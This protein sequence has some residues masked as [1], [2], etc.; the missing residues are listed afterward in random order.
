MSVDTGESV[1]DL[2]PP[3]PTRDIKGPIFRSKHDPTAPPTCSTFGRSTAATCLVTN[4]GGDTKS[5]PKAHPWKTEHSSFGPKNPD[6]ANPKKFV[7]K[8]KRELPK[9]GRFVYHDAKKPPIPKPTEEPAQRDIQQPKN[10]IKMNTTAALNASPKRAE[11]RSINFLQKP[12]YG[13]VPGYLNDVKQE[14]QR[15]THLVQQ[16]MSQHQETKSRD[17]PKMRQ[18][19]EDERLQLLGNL[20][21]KWEEINKLYQ[22]CTHIIAL[23]SRSKIQKKEQY[24]RELADLERAIERLSKKFVFVEDN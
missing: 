8:Q 4:A 15:E 11:D 7:K 13:K 16:I 12:D 14:I 5:D 20:K 23:D 6:K 21:A 9:K 22:G 10:F 24:E 17:V 3:P 19:S 1:Y 2:I 18:L